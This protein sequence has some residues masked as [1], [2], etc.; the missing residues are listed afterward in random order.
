VPVKIRRYI[1]SDTIVVN[2]SIDRAY[3]I[4]SDPVMVPK[5]ENGIVKIEV[6][7]EISNSER[8][9]RSHLKVLGITRPYI[10][11]YRYSKNRH[12]SGHQEF[13]HFFRGFFSLSFKSISGGTQIY[14]KEGILSTWPFFASILGLIYFKVLSPSGVDSE[15][16]RLKYIIETASADA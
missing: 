8:L 1:V 12:Y 6:I 3:E 15:L 10:Y 11:R 14:H 4:A 13:G 5:Y 16:K 7:D 2:S 9:V